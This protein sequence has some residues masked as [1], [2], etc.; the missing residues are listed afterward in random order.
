M[1]GFCAC[2]V[3]SEHDRYDLGLTNCCIWCWEK[4][5]NNSKDV[6]SRTCWV[7]WSCFWYSHFSPVQVLSAWSI[8]WSR[9]CSCSL[10]GTHFGQVDV[11]WVLWLIDSPTLRQELVKAIPWFLPALRFVLHNLLAHN[12]NLCSLLE[13]FCS[14]ERN[15]VKCLLFT[16]MVYQVPRKQW[17]ILWGQCSIPYNPE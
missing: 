4:E 8:L 11:D 7:L 16:Q 6:V 17:K 10:L 3:L 5:F 15:I 1:Y 2:F 9:W 14:T 13:S 12:Q